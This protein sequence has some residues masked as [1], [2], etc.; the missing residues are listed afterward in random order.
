VLDV[1]LFDSRK[2]WCLD[3][4]TLQEL[5]ECLAWALDFDLHIAG[6]VSDPAA[7]SI[8]DRQA[9]DEGTESHALHDPR[10]V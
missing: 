2:R 1:D 10:H 8:A 4:E 5:P 6:G 9:M 3:L 7:Q